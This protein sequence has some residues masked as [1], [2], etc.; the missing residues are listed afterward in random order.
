M[1]AAH[2]L[3]KSSSSSPCVRA[4]SLY[5]WCQGSP[6]Y[7]RVQHSGTPSHGWAADYHAVEGRGDTRTATW[8][9]NRSTSPNSSSPS[10]VLLQ[11]N[12]TAV[13]DVYLPTIPYSCPLLSRQ[14]PYSPTIPAIPAIYTICIIYAQCL[15][16]YRL[17]CLERKQQALPKLQKLKLQGLCGGH[18][19]PHTQRRHHPHTHLSLAIARRRRFI[20]ERFRQPAAA[21][22]ANKGMHLTYTPYCTP[23]TGTT[24]L[25]FG[26]AAK[27]MAGK[28][29]TQL[30]RGKL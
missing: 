5:G 23:Y 28:H 30:L 24:I 2:A 10:P 9:T 15:L 12:G 25:R 20:G 26:S 4:R 1:Y 8:A 13:Q 17:E 27:A 3:F 7:D 18:R 29:W 19:R 6:I 11:R 22:K 21:T 14:A 16:P